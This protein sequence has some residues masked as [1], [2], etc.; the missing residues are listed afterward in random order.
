MPRLLTWERGCYALAGALGLYFRYRKTG[1]P[2]ELLIGIP[3][4]I[5]C[6]EIVIAV[7]RWETKVREDLSLAAQLTQRDRERK[8]KPRGPE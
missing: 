8:H 6:F 5:I 7:H 4:L 2:I 1:D 3:V